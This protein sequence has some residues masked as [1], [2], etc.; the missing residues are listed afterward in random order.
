MLFVGHTQ[1][2]RVA[3]GYVQQTKR[4]VSVPIGRSSGTARTNYN[5]LPLSMQVLLRTI[6]STEKQNCLRETTTLE[7]QLI[8]VIIKLIL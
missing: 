4:S 8:N 6:N 1:T 5:A 2:C 7:F 3:M